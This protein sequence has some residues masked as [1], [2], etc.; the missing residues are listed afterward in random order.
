MRRN[1]IIAGSLALLLALTGCTQIGETNPSTPPTST[2]PTPAA[3]PSTSPSTAS[4]PSTSPSASAAE[5]TASEAPAAQLPVVRFTS[6]QTSVDVTI[7][8]ENPTARDFLSML[9]LTV[10]VEEF[11]GREK[12][13]D[14]PRELVT[15]GSPGSDPVDGD[16]IY[17][18]PWGNLGFYYN[19]S[20][21]GY[22]DQTIHLGTYDA[23]AE[24]LELL[25]GSNITVELVD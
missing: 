10:P 3:T 4:A 11:A 20:G 6:G 2:A 9:P 22:S 15:E 5:S 21:I 17:F 24:Q 23:T 7:K 1:H 14:L 16:L 25:E 19:T 8:P 12:L 13:A 18:K